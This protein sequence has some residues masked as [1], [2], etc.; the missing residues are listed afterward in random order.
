MYVWKLNIRNKRTATFHSSGLG[1]P[2]PNRWDL[3]NLRNDHH[4][5][6]QQVLHWQSDVSSAF[7]GNLRSLS[8]LQYPLPAGWW[9]C[10]AKGIK[11]KAVFVCDPNDCERHIKNENYSIEW[12]WWTLIVRVFCDSRGLL[13][14]SFG[15]L[16][17]YRKNLKNAD[18]KKAVCVQLIHRAGSSLAVI[19]IVLTAEE[20]N[21]SALNIT[22]IFSRKKLFQWLNNA[23]LGHPSSSSRYIV[24][25]FWDCG[26]FSMSVFR[27]GLFW[28]E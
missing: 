2:L 17:S 4:C 19:I 8:C 1:F 3:L 6:I 11:G 15:L 12:K 10:N 27:H 7:V 13:H 5:E 26:A 24:S 18:L 21:H 25:L 9:N 23:S 22:C 16:T 20:A 28:K 14:R